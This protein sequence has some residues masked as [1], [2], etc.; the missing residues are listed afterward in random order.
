MENDE[1]KLVGSEEIEA[2]EVPQ[3]DSLA[4][5][6]KTSKVVIGDEVKM[7]GCVRVRGTLTTVNKTPNENE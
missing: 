6:E 5:E 4:T 2:I 7:K 3:V 1:A